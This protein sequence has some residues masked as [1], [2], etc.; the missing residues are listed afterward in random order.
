M[1]ARRMRNWL[2]AKITQQ[3]V[4]ISMA[5][6]LGLIPKL[7]LTALWILGSLILWNSLTI[8]L[9]AIIAVLS[10]TGFAIQPWLNQLGYLSTQAEIVQ[11]CL[12]SIRSLP[13]LPWFR[14]DNISVAGGL[15]AGWVAAP[16]IWLLLYA[17]QTRQRSIAERSALAKS[18][19]VIVDDSHQSVE[20]FQHLHPIVDDKPTPPTPD[21]INPTDCKSIEE[22]VCLVNKVEE[23][24]IRI[25][26]PHVDQPAHDSLELHETLIEIVRFQSE[27]MQTIQGSTPAPKLHYSE[28]KSTTLRT[29]EADLPDQNRSDSIEGFDHVPVAISDKADQSLRAEKPKDEALRYLLWHLSSSK[30]TH[31]AKETTS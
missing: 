23:A 11:D 31:R 8:E 13:I 24:M 16:S 25:D 19:V 18:K 3:T 22:P 28:M 12:T 20:T 5:I 7:N 6:T 17:M 26:N 27:V 29:V 1:K 15:A 2:S 9:V 30:D 4:V 14:W 21:E 10:I